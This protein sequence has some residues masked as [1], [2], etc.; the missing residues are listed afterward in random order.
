[1]F[2]LQLP[3]KLEL[4]PPQTPPLPKKRKKERKKERDKNK[5]PKTS[6]YEVKTQTMY[7]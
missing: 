7:K 4:I 1:M 3:F 6:K 5:T 2:W